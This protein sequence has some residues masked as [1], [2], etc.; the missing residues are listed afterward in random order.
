[1]TFS[2][3]VAF[4]TGGGSGMGQLAARNLAAQGVSVAAL[5]VNTSGLADTA[6]GFD[7]ILTIPADVTEPADIE[8]AVKLVEQDLGPID[9]VYNAAAIFPTGRLLDQDTATIQRIMDINYG[10]VVNVTKLALP[11]ML[12][13]GSG[14]FINFASLAGWL[15]VLYLGA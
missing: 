13:R 6:T 4:I 14:D 11:G 9:R 8:Q 5:D 3:R 10:G 7:N 15:P 2:G 12:E 1:M